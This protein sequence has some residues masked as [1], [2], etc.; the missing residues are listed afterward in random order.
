MPRR[1]NLAL[2][3]FTAAPI[4]L[5]FAAYCLRFR[6]EANWPIVAWPMLSLAGGWAVVHCR[7]RGGFRAA[8]LAVLR[9]AQVPVGLALV[10]L[11]YV[12]AV[13]QPWSIV[14]A[15]DRTRDMRGWS[16]L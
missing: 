5:Y 11:I 3:I 1:A 12:Q 16:G 2:P 6:V 15:I 8:T 4:L 10:L 7:P 14:Q 9:R 13:W